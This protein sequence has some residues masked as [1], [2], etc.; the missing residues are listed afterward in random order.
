MFPRTVYRLKAKSE[1]KIDLP[2]LIVPIHRSDCKYNQSVL[3][4]VN[5]Y[6]NLMLLRKRVAGLG[7]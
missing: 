5:R 2:L 6:V 7:V 3:M 1:L 4:L